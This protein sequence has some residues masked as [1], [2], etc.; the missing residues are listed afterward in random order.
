[1]KQFF[2]QA[3]E[4]PKNT[5]QIAAEEYLRERNSSGLIEKKLDGEK[6]AVLLIANGASKLAYLTDG[7]RA[8]SMPLSEFN[9]LQDQV[10]RIRAIQLPDVAGRLTLF[11]LES[12][13]K[14]EF[15]I[16]EPKAWDAQV[17]QWKQE[18]WSGLAEITSEQCQGLVLFWKGEAEKSD[19]IFSTT[20]G[21]ISEFPGSEKDRLPW[22]VAAYTLLPSRQGYQCSVLRLGA[23]HWSHKILSRYREMVGQKLLLTMNRELNRLIGP[24][25]W[26][27]ELEENNVLD[28]HFF[29]YLM[30]AAYAYRALFMAMGAQMSFVIGNNLTSRL[31]NETFEQIH[32]DERAL[33]QSQRLIPAA[34]SE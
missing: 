20:G 15:T 19:V 2:N 12:E 30:D 25:H 11:A 21:F 7:G 34:F 13:V 17:E 33:L 18:Q 10:K 16:L 24:W 26:N 3:E 4:L 28:A 8:K 31:L 23:V 14:N 29:P 6:S 1:M 27:I 5:S 22:E 9:S 32:P